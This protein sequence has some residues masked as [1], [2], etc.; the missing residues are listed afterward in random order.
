MIRLIPRMAQEWVI[1][2][3]DSWVPTPAACIPDLEATEETHTDTVGWGEDTETMEVMAAMAAMLDMVAVDMAAMEDMAGMVD[4][5]N[6]EDM[7]D[8]EDR[9]VTVAD[10]AMGSG[11]VDMAGH[12]TEATVDMECRMVT[13]QFGHS[14]IDTL[15]HAMETSSIRTEMIR[16]KKLITAL[17]STGQVM[18][19][20]P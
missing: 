19:E 7:V 2:W 16:F 9:G 17:T 14:M 15:E 5:E 3:G 6:M 11:M 8:T 12:L 4:M 10:M 20:L 13:G 18:H 1:A